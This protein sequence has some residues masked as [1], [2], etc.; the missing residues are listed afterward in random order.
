VARIL[1]VDDDAQARG[2]LEALLRYDGHEVVLAANGRQGL[3][4]AR[5]QG[6]SVILSDVKMPGMDGIEFCREIRKDPDLKDAYVILAT[7]MDT[8]SQRTEGIAAGADDYIGKPIRADE[9]Q[10]RVRLAIRFRV[11]REEIAD[12]HRRTAEADR[13]RVDHESLRA[14]VQEM[15]GDLGL[16]LGTLLDAARRAAENA[17]SGDMKFA[18]GSIEAVAAEI[19]A[20][21]ARVSPRAGA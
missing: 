11:L 12:L 20:L 15:R 7:G 17:R 1:V 16:S 6:C 19:E 5:D 18:L 10:A 13:A 9:L 2:V 8:S 3:L 21:R 4:A 14:K